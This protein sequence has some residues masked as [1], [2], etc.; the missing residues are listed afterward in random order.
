M[1]GAIK[2]LAATA[3]FGIGHSLLASR[4]AKRAAERVLGTEGRSALYRPFYLVQSVVTFGGLVWYLRRQPRDTVYRVPQPWATL[5]RIGQAGGLMHAARAAH[6]VG[7]PRMLGV[8]GLTAWLTE[9]AVP[10]PPEAQGPAYEGGAMKD[11]GPFRWHSSPWQKGDGHPVRGT[12]STLASA[13]RHENS[14]PG[15]TAVTAPRC[16]SERFCVPTPS[17]R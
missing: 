13:T 5:M 1:R 14:P 11:T 17:I 8:P 3:L 12:R 9:G 15:R 4:S 7:I 10:A 16:C 2:I 6:H